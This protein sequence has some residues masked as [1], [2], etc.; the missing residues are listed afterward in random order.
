MPR[1]H[2]VDSGFGSF[3]LMDEIM[4]SGATATMSMPSNTKKWLWGALDRSCGIDCG[5]TAWNPDTGLLVSSFKVISETGKVHQIKTLASGFHI[6]PPE[7]SEIC[8]SAV[9]ASRYPPPTPTLPPPVS[10]SF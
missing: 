2:I 4:E 9:T 6:T 10:L 8:I 1:H 3:F 7:D 5:R